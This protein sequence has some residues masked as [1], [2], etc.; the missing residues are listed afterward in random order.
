MG[1]HIGQRQI[2]RRTALRGIAA[3]VGVTLLA[4]CGGTGN[5]SSAATA[6]T[7][8]AAATIS[9]DRK[10]AA[11]ATTTQIQDFVKNVGGDR[12]IVAGILKPNV[13]PHDYEPTVADAN[14]IAKSDIVFVHGIGLDSWLDKTITGASVAAPVITTDGIAVLKGDP[15]EPEGD[16]HF[17]FDPTLVQ[18][19]ITNI[20]NGLAKVDPTQASAY[21]ANA[22]SYADQLTQ[23]DGQMMGIFTQIPKEQRK[24]VTNHDAFRYLARRYDLTIVGAVI[25]SLSDTAEPSAKQINDLIETIKQ[26]KVK[27]IFAESSANP[28]VAQQVASETG[29]AIVDTLYGDTLG[30]PGSTGDTYLKMMTDDA[31]TIANALK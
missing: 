12:V 1:Q 31:T 11:A 15:N 8:V 17:W 10:V 4:A 5:G 23:L 22:K 13:D 19:M 7:N 20:A 29:I 25:P 2:R 30:A 21:Q 6:S 24:L 9:P 3:S 26:E 18:T 16:P 27:A 14:T 28:K